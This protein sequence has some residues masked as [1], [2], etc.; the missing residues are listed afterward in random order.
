MEKRRRV[1]GAEDGKSLQNT[2]TSEPGKPWVRLQGES[3]CGHYLVSELYRACRFAYSGISQ[4]STVSCQRQDWVLLHLF[5]NI[6]LLN[7]ALLDNV[8]LGM[9]TFDVQLFLFL[10]TGILA[11]FDA[12]HV[13]IS[14]SAD[15]ANH[16]NN[17]YLGRY[18]PPLCRLMCGARAGSILN[19]SGIQSV[20][21]ELVYSWSVPLMVRST[22]RTIRELVVRTHAFVVLAVVFH[23]ELVLLLE[24]RCRQ[25]GL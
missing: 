22:Q 2:T 23:V 19:W 8:Y 1:G 7:N 18:I 15:A 21:L 14:D 24:S 20:I 13:E 17:T 5:D 25:M 16:L 10:T 12:D 9:F 6:Y 11:W 3:C 4:H